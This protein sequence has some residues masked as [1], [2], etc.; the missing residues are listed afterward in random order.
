MRFSCGENWKHKLARLR[1]WHPFF[2]LW[3]RTVTVENGRDVCVWLQWIERKGKFYSFPMDSWWDWEYRERKPGG[4]KS[5]IF[6]AD[7]KG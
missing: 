2:A 4:Y 7:E 6:R 5:G 3:P 1:E